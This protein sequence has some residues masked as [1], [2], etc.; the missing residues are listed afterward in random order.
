MFQKRGTHKHYDGWF[1]KNKTAIGVATMI[2][3]IIGAGILGIPYLV[4]Q[5]GLLYG[6][7][8]ILL[9]GIAYIFIN[10]FV[11]EIVLRT[12][13]SH[14]MTGYAEKYLG[15]YAKVILTIA[16]VFGTYGAL[17]AYLIGEGQTLFTLVEWGS[18]LVFS[19]IFGAVG[20]LIV[21]R[22]LKAT[23]RA[24]L[25]LN[26][27][28]L[29]V[30]TLIGIFSFRQI[31]WN[32]ISHLDFAKLLMPYGTILF[33]YLGFASIPEVRE[34]LGRETKKMKT[35]ILAGSIIPIIVYILFTFVVVGIVGLD[36]F[37]VLLPNERIAT[38]ALSLY[39]APILGT[40][41]NIMAFLTMFTSFLALSLI[42]LDIYKKDYR[43]SFRWAFLFT[44]LVPFAVV[45]LNFTSFISILSVVGTF[46]GGVEGILVVLMFWRCKKLGD[47]KPEFTLRQNRIIGTLLILMFLS[48]MVYFLVKL[49]S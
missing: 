3:T 8:V 11:G 28:F 38:V 40:L 35:V 30:I 49:L 2:G 10:L 19:L 12:K 13:A 16:M 1:A 14:Q 31:T 34:E 24:E 23:G 4:A 26:T 44:F 7:I 9:L 15:K 6:L 43:I 5:T 39:S 33:A 48:G 46:T 47:R 27:V 17:S 41:A 36:N 18:P 20:I 22:G 32:N 21:S 37:D 42:L 25:I 29:G 45:L